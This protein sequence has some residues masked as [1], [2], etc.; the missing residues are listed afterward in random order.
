MKALLLMFINFL[1]F[2]SMAQ[3][4]NQKYIVTNKINDIE[5]REYLPA[6]YASVTLE[7]NNAKQNSMFRILANYIFGGNDEN[8]KIAMTA[9]VHMQKENNGEKDALTM[10]FVMPSK[11]NLDDLSKPNDSRV[12]IY[13]SNKKKY[14]AIGYGG[15]NSDSKSDDYYKKLK[16]VLKNNNIKYSGNPIYLG[17]DPPYK[18]WGRKNEILLEL[19]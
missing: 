2:I 10:K 6:I 16:T 12:N 19:E 3:T 15:Y 9:P 13:K 4:E 8:Q 1:T 7:E 11:Y 14:A 17:Y 18:F 5:I